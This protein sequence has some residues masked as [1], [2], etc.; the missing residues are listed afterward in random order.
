MTVTSSESVQID[1]KVRIVELLYAEFFKSN[2]AGLAIQNFM[3]TLDI[4]ENKLY[5][6]LEILES[7]WFIQKNQ[8]NRY[9]ITVSGINKYEELIPPSEITRKQQER[10]LIL[11]V[12]LPQY[13]EQHVYDFM[14]SDELANRTNMTDRLY[15]L[16]TVE[17]LSQSGLVYLE[18]AN[19]GAFWIRLTS[20]GYQSLQDKVTNNLTVMVGAYKILFNLEN[21]LRQYIE[22]KMR[23]VLRTDWWEKGVSEGVRAKAG[24]RKAAEGNAGWSISLTNG[25]SDYLLFEDLSKII[26]SNWDNVFKED[27]HDQSKI[28]LKLTELEIIRHAI[29]HTRMLTLEGMT[30]LQQYSNE[31]LT[32]TGEK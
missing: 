17:Y 12:L 10:K 8:I 21:H 32:L 4:P 9:V 16:A 5:P 6:E 18:V 24:K 15:L 30:R 14:T 22:S 1:P 11:E 27:L 2:I 13:T 31:L 19:G 7:N 26:I 20:E 3:M 29:A 23:N 25:E 28:I